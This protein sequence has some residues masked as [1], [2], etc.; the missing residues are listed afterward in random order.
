ML[1]CT[2]CLNVGKFLGRVG[3]CLCALARLQQPHSNGACLCVCVCF[4]FPV[5]S[6]TLDHWSSSSQENSKLAAMTVEIG[7]ISQENDALLRELAIAK[8]AAYIAPTAAAVAKVPEVPVT[9]MPELAPV[10]FRQQVRSNAFE[11]LTFR[12]EGQEVLTQHHCINFS[13]SQVETKFRHNEQ[14]TYQTYAVAGE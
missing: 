11:R 9:T 7:R 14:N 3:I 2:T 4:N 12:D 13:L 1:R 10:P 6:P 5:V 8:S